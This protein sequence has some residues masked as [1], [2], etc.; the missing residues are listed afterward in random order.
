MFYS[1]NVL[2]VSDATLLPTLMVEAVHARELATEKA[3][4]ARELLPRKLLLLENLLPRELPKSEPSIFTT[5]RTRT[6]SVVK[7]MC[8]S[9]NSGKKNKQDTNMAVRG[10]QR[11]TRRGIEFYR[12]TSKR[13]IVP[14]KRGMQGN[15]R[16]RW[17]ERQDSISSLLRFH[18]LSSLMTRSWFIP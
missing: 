15:R 14:L 10:W 12:R 13:N 6:Q 7:L 11:S 16:V 17:R 2:V 18:E 8:K 1:G 3:A 4:N 5:S 9:R